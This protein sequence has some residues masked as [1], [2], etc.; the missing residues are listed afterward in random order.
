MGVL[1]PCVAA[2][3]SGLIP[4]DGSGPFLDA[5][6]IQIGQYTVMHAWRVGVARTL[7]A[8]VGVVIGSTTYRGT[9]SPVVGR[10]VR[11][12]TSSGK[13]EAIAAARRANQTKKVVTHAPV[14]APAPI[15]F[16]ARQILEASCGS[17]RRAVIDALRASDP[18]GYRE[19]ARI[20]Y[21]GTDAP[22]IEQRRRAYVYAFTRLI[23]YG[24]TQTNL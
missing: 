15:S 13:S 20:K 2:T 23:Q 19:Y 9:C 3:E 7:L 12:F 5:S 24:Y 21:E 18:A 4:V 16:D 8:S 14:Y 17:I 1:G 6:G 22:K 11:A 10:A